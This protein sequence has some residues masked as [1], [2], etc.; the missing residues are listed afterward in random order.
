[1]Q[2]AVRE[3]PLDGGET[4]TK[5]ALAGAWG[6]TGHGA[7]ERPG[8]ARVL[9]MLTDGAASVG[10][11]PASTTGQE[12]AAQGI[13]VIAIGAGTG[14]FQ[15]D[16]EHATAPFYEPHYAAS[17]RAAMDLI[18]KVQLQACDAPVYLPCG[19]S[20]TWPSGQQHAP[21]RVRVDGGHA[22]VNITVSDPRADIFAAP[23]GPVA[24]SPDHFQFSSVTGDR[25]EGAA[26]AVLSVLG[27]TSATRAGI[28]LAVWDTAPQRAQRQPVTMT[29][30]C[31]STA[32][33]AGPPPL[34][35]LACKT[36]VSY[37]SGAM[38]N[39]STGA[40]TE[41]DCLRDCNNN[42]TCMFWDWD[43]N[44][45][46]LRSSRGSAG[47]AETAT[48]GHVGGARACKLPGPSTSAP[49]P[50]G[51]S[52]M[53]CGH[54]VDVVFLIDTSTSMSSAP[55][56]GYAG[57]FNDSLKFIMHV[58]GFF[59][60]GPAASQTHVGIATFSDTVDVHVLPGAMPAG[61]SLGDF[62]DTIVVR[63]G[64][65]TK[66]S[67]GLQMAREVMLNESRVGVPQVVVVLTDGAADTGYAPDAEAQALM[68][69]QVSV[70]AVGVGTSA[71][72]KDQV[73][74]MAGKQSGRGSLYGSEVQAPSLRQWAPLGAAVRRMVCGAPAHV[75]CGARAEFSIGAG[76]GML[77]TVP[78]PP[79][80]AKSQWTSVEVTVASGGVDLFAHPSADAWV[81]PG[82]DNNDLARLGVADSNPQTVAFGGAA[83]AILAILLQQSGAPSD[84]VGSVAVSCDATTTST[85]TTTT[86]S[87]TTETRPT[88]NGV[89]QPLACDEYEFSSCSSTDTS[90]SVSANCP[91]LCQ[92]CATTVGTQATTTMA[93]TMDTTARCNGVPDADTCPADAADCQIPVLGPLYREVCKVLCGTCVPT[94]VT[95]TAATTTTVDPY[96]SHPATTCTHPV[97]LVFL[98]DR[99]E[100]MGL[101]SLGGYSDVYKDALRF[102]A[103][104]LDQA[105]DL[106][107]TRVGLATFAGTFDVAFHLGEHSDEEA[108]HRALENIDK[109]PGDGATRTGHALQQVREEML[110]RARP[111]S[112]GVARVV[113]VISDGLADAGYG[114]DEQAALLKEDLVTII[115]V[116]V[117]SNG[118]GANAKRLASSDALHF[119]A[120]SLKEPA[121]PALVS[122]VRGV[123]QGVCRAPALLRCQSSVSVTMAPGSA[124][125]FR[126]PGAE[127]EIEVTA[128]TPPSPPACNGAPQS[129]QCGK[130]Y[131]YETCNSPV[132]GAIVRASCP[133]L[134][135]WCP[136]VLVLNGTTAGAGTQ[137]YQGT[138]DEYSCTDNDASC[139]LLG[140]SF[141]NNPLLPEFNALCPKTCNICGPAPAVMTVFGPEATLPG[142]DVNYLNPGPG[143]ASTTVRATCCDYTAKRAEV[144]S[145]VCVVSVSTDRCSPGSTTN[146]A[147]LRSC[148][149]TANKGLVREIILDLPAGDSE[150]SLVHGAITVDVPDGLRISNAGAVNVV[151]R[152]T[153]DNDGLVVRNSANVTISGLDFRGHADGIS[154]INTNASAVYG[155]VISDNKKAGVRI[156]ETCNGIVVGSVAQ[157]HLYISGNG[158]SGVVNNGRHTH[159]ACATIGV[160]DAKLHGIALGSKKTPGNA[161]HGVASFGPGTIIG[162]NSCKTII[163]GNRQYGVN[164]AKGSAGSH[165][166]HAYIGITP[167]GLAAAGNGIA[168]VIVEAPNCIIGAN[169]ADED[170]AVISGNGFGGAYSTQIG[171]VV[172]LQSATNTTV[173]GA[174]IGLA[175]SGS[176]AVS[177]RLVGM[178]IRADDC[179]VGSL[180]SRVRTVV[181]GNRRRCAGKGQRMALS[182]PSSL[183]Q[184]VPANL[185][186]YPYDYPYKGIDVRG[187]RVVVLGAF[188]GTDISGTKAV[189]NENGIMVRKEASGARIGSRSSP[190]LVS[191][192]EGT[193]VLCYAPKFRLAGAYIG[194]GVDGHTRVANHR[195]GVKLF[196]DCVQAVVG[197]TASAEVATLVSGNKRSGVVVEGP[198]VRIGNVRVGVSQ[199]SAT[200]IG[201]GESGVVFQGSFHARPGSI[202]AGTV[203]AHNGQHGILVK[204]LV[205]QGPK[206][207]SLP[208]AAPCLVTNNSMD[209]IHVDSSGRSETE[210]SN[211][212]VAGNGY[213]G[214]Y[215]GP[216]AAGTQIGKAGAPV[217]LTENGEDGVVSWAKE[218]VVRSCTISANKGHGI[219]LQ[220]SA[221]A[222]QISNTD[223]GACNLHPPFTC[224]I[225]LA[226]DTR[227]PQLPPS[228]LLPVFRLYA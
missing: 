132:Y 6:M 17:V 144:Q 52:Q 19:S 93:T 22:Q 149:D 61:Q 85:T 69:G 78:A 186:D 67:A 194:V 125:H 174:L 117:G 29:A 46:R 193:G 62:V 42:A 95:A 205:K 55:Y 228:P 26:A 147:T 66:T 88:C 182:D 217:S 204:A 196:P 226:Q 207:G 212:L 70:V 143:T 20:I 107:A 211:T 81:R 5:E 164:F 45:C 138:R 126:V 72:I 113:V 84:A 65:A 60:V 223:I 118:A 177:N 92:T 150:V 115:S 180:D 2:A 68:D 218:T 101:S 37:P 90:F 173:A 33:P 227:F 7:A 35:P 141:C 30:T 219:W 159:V 135:G 41:A 172:V 39:S 127:S 122:V 199:D 59:D 124:W 53:T 160:S 16:L 179:T 216:G 191:G 202:G 49:V 221:S 64:R 175:A 104:V 71:R 91:V 89:P 25:D 183:R 98:I 222:V 121:P 170:P 167:D 200:A 162:S 154:F 32:A 152:G 187:K 102:V 11:E 99:S 181:S 38:V 86:I 73:E 208:G 105:F 224:P 13:T 214:V 8:V 63:A 156:S 111:L 51:S 79:A 123:Q 133:I 36:G 4:Y 137:L 110:T 10:H 153:G 192:N 198:A 12:L 139:P 157:Q 103:D 108:L 171:G 28:T 206:I 166:R 188:V 130:Q 14:P 151:I 120:L 74:A 131:N 43:T 56:G 134:C 82:P 75:P 189:P 40:T 96:A 80:T 48:G 176:A 158:H 220:S 119:A 128:S 197:D 225:A 213:A 18:T 83:G 97:D 155:G 3:I 145:P 165:L 210:I 215:V 178:I 109:L 168:G 94:T 203:V 148:V 163:S 136:G 34:P 195:D 27:N 47:Q 161:F 142:L 77:L 169:D 54:A 112:E 116:G 57:A 209:G 31:G 44:V 15:T 190:T 87:T 100:S 76:T 146:S 58:A 114:P 185:A 21:T 1:M 140:A 129:S 184:C 201:N 50:P 23:S 106:G 24:P 9:I